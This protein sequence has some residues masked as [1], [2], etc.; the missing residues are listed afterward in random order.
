MRTNF[1]DNNGNINPNFTSNNPVVNPQFN[2]DGTLKI[3][4]GSNEQ[5]VPISFATNPNINLDFGTMSANA[6]F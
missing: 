5:I 1:T 3:T 6:P 2:T 4:T